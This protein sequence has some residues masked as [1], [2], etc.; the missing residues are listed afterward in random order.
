MDN[1]LK[2]GIYKNHFFI[3]K[4]FDISPFWVKNF[5]KYKDDEKFLNNQQ[6]N[7]ASY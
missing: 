5:N 3:N 6:I 4:M 1:C 2:I 7:E